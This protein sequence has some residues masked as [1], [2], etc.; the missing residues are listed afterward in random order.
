[1]FFCDDKKYIISETKNTANKGDF[2][3]TK[4]AGLPICYVRSFKQ[5]KQ[6]YV[7]DVNCKRGVAKPKKEVRR[8]L[9]I[10]QN[11]A[12]LTSW[13]QPMFLVAGGYLHITNN[14]FYAIQ[15]YAFE[16]T[17]KTKK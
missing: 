13:N 11:I 14:N 7:F 12:F 17:Y 5:A 10:N 3:I 9:Q 2:V 8:F 4:N 15:K 1:M 6:K 16:H